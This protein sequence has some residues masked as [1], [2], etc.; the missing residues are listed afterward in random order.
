[1]SFGTEEIKYL[2]RELAKYRKKPPY[3]P[4][5]ALVA[6]PRSAST[7]ILHMLNYIMLKNGITGHDCMVRRSHDGSGVRS[8]TKLQIQ[9]EQRWISDKS[10][11][12]KDKRVVLCVRN[13]ID[14]HV[15]QW[16]LI[17]NRRKQGPIMNVHSFEQFF[18]NP[19]F[20]LAMSIR[21]LNDWSEQTDVPKVFHL[22]KFEESIDRSREA[23]VLADVLNAV[24]FDSVP[25][26]VCDTVTK[27]FSFKNLRESDREVDFPFQEMKRGISLDPRDPTNYHY[28]SGKI[29][30]YKD[31]LSPKTAAWAEALVDEHLSSYYNYYKTGGLYGAASV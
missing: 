15:S 13:P 4:T 16:H 31:F 1:M 25:M 11:R 29:L 5:S 28:R 30:G 17:V 21:W 8:A 12:W 3:L 6:I 24:G 7:R 9:Q 20:G 22:V 23:H 2:K 19:K 26:E 14:V 10:V 27:I 18:R